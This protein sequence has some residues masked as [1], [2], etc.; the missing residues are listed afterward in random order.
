M[1]NYGIISTNPDDIDDDTIINM[2]AM[3]YGGNFENAD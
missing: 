1:D 3:F 2:Y